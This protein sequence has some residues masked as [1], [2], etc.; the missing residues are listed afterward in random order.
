MT[1]MEL[2]YLVG[3]CC[4]RQNPEAVKIVLGDMVYDE[5]A[6]KRRD[7]DI[8][9]TLEEGGGVLRAFK[10]I[11]VKQESKP[12]DVATVEQLCLK[13]SDMPKITHRAIVSAAGFTD[14][15]RKKAGR[16]GVE[17]YSFVPWENPLSEDFPSWSGSPAPQFALRF[18]RALLFWRN[19]RVWLTTAGGPSSFNVK[20]DSVLL[21]ASGAKHPVFSTFEDFRNA[22]LRRSTEVL[23]KLEPAQTFLHSAPAALETASAAQSPYWVQAHTM[24]VG[25]DAVCLELEGQLLQIVQATVSG[26][27]YWEW[28]LVKPDYKLLRRVG[29]GAVYAGAAVVTGRVP[30]ELMC[31]VLDPNSP[32]CGVHFVNLTKAQQNMLKQMEIYAKAPC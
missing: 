5:A 23:W 11:E 31:F 9:I 6:E 2:Q 29:D 19:E 28:P 14:A 4:L 21:T 15:A 13:F 17:L 3:L 1:P 27:L 18:E 12:L 22:L 16:H 30:G 26:S 20:S 8:T 7:V 24:D 32:M 10:A 25:A